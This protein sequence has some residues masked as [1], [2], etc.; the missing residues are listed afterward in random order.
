MG[1]GP[2]TFNVIGNVW[3]L[4]CCNPEDNSDG[5]GWDIFSALFGWT[6]SA[7]I[8]SV[9]SYVFYW[10]VAIGILV[11]LNYSEGRMTIFGR[12]SAE[13]RRRLERRALKEAAARDEKVAEGE[14]NGAVAELPL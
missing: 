1:D 12:R 8:G 9:L 5:H 10:L 13:G 14:E 3:H 11:Y 7:T 2:G 4:D 6:N